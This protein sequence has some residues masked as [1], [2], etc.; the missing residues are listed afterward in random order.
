MTRPESKEAYFTMPDLEHYRNPPSPPR[1]PADFVVIAIATIAFVV[2]WTT[3]GEAD[4]AATVAVGILS[5]RPPPEV[6]PTK[7]S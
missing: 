5:F 6:P 3:T 2:V 7:P 4:A 1:S